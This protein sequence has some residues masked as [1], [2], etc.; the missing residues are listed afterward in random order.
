MV[1]LERWSAL[2]REKDH[3]REVLTLVERVVMLRRWP[4]SRR[5]NGHVTEVNTLMEGGHQRDR[6]GEFNGGRIAS[7]RENV[8]EVA[9]LREGK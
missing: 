7:R 4:V 5:E 1:M 3:V 8:I 9:C 2:K 6:S